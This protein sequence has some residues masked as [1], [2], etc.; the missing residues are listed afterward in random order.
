MLLGNGLRYCRLCLRSPAT[1]AVANLFLRKELALYQERQVKPQRAT[2]AT[3]LVLVWLVHWFDWRQAL[4]IVQPA[5]LLH[6]HRQESR[7]FWQWNSR[8]GRP[9]LP[10]EL[11]ALIRQMAR[12]NP[13]WGQERI[14]NELLLKLGL[15][16]SPQAVQARYSVVNDSEGC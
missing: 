14:A 15:R 12:E 6:W 4:I 13:T 1:L 5:T 16:V 2:N 7:L 9:T 8:S 3:R 11:Q 10:P